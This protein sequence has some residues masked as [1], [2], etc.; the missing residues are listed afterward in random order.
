MKNPKS[1]FKSFLLLITIG[2]LFSCQQS[3][4]ESISTI[5]DEVSENEDLTKEIFMV[6]EDMPFLSGS[7]D[8]FSEYLSATLKY[9]SEAKEAG[10]EG[11]VFVQFV[12]DKTGK[13]TDVEVVKGIG[14][15][16]DKEAI[17]VVRE[18]AAW[19]PGQQRGRKVNVRLT[20]PITFKLG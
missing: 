10:I 11:K 2:I 18:S 6:V 20:I 13:L 3:T 12:V 8:A 14:G 1:L 16:C 4:D 7:K 17:R 9:P 19:N 5:Q 15:G